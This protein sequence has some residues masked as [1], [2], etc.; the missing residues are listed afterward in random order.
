MGAGAGFLSRDKKKSRKKMAHGGQVP[1]HLI[2]VLSNQTTIRKSALQK[3]VEDNHLSKDDVLSIISGIGRKQIDSSDVMMAWL[4]GIGSEEN[5]ELVEFA[6]SGKAFDLARG[7]KTH[8]LKFQKVD[9]PT[10]ER[11]GI[12]RHKAQGDE[13]IFVID[14]YVT[15]DSKEEYGDA[16]FGGNVHLY[17]RDKDGKE[18]DF[19]R[20]L[21][22]YDDAVRFA[23]YQNSGLI[24]IGSARYAKGGR[25]EGEIRYEG[26]GLAELGGERGG[27]V[28]LSKEALKKAKVTYYPVIDSVEF[29]I[30]GSRVHADV[31]EDENRAKDY[32]NFREYLTGHY[33]VVNGKRR[34]L[35]D[36]KNDGEI[37]EIFEGNPFDKG[38]KLAKGGRTTTQGLHKFTL[39]AKMVAEF[40]LG[41]SERNRD[42]YHDRANDRFYMFAFDGDLEE[43]LNYYPIQKLRG[44]VDLMTEEGIKGY[45]KGGTTGSAEERA[46]EEYME[47][48]DVDREEAEEQFLGEF[49]SKADWA[50][51]FVD[52]TGGMESLIDPERFYRIDTDGFRQF[53]LDEASER[54]ADI[55]KDN[56]DEYAEKFDLEEEYEEAVEEDFHIRTGALSDF[57]T[58]LQEKEEEA[59]LDDLMQNYT[60]AEA[61]INDLGP[62]YGM[63]LEALENAHLIMPD[64]DEVADALEDDGYVFIEEDFKTF[65]FNPNMARGGRTKRMKK[66]GK[67][68]GLDKYGSW[69]YMDDDGTLFVRYQEVGEDKAPK[70]DEDDDEWGVVEERAFSTMERQEF[71]KDMKKLFGRKPKLG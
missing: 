67:V 25:T 58:M 66:G 31:D 13:Y 3:L 71:E 36:M 11:E 10:L 70:W 32:R 29:R 7:G 37:D 6:K 57:I 35:I 54:S 28:Q 30:G 20:F 52:D 33:I 60:T 63:D 53:A 46:F 8:S 1:D 24:G 21:D 41:G 17:V 40:G 49:D 22:D 26:E 48:Y 45:A 19:V 34:Y 14:E 51:E 15:S 62:N 44:L 42:I 38:V 47:D 18:V 27:E 5:E 16:E 69:Y 9:F 61:I 59:V 12:Q 50:A 68:K 23:N 39:P 4:M 56:A 43:I 64:Y 2:D 65:V 55:D